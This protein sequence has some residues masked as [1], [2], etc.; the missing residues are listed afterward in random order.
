MYGVEV[1]RVVRQE[2]QLAPAL[3]DL[4][5]FRGATRAWEVLYQRDR[6]PPL[7]RSPG[8]TSYPDPTMHPSR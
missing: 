2:H 8:R 6:A 5:S 3:L 4:L 1:G 7:M